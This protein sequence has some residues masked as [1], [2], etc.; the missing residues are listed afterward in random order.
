VRAEVPFGNDKS[1]RPDNRGR[2]GPEGCASLL[3]RSFI[4]FSKTSEKEWGMSSE[5]DDGGGVT[6]NG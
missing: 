3:G 5:N 4:G 1:G 2:A 6:P